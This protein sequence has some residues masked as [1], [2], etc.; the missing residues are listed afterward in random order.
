MEHIAAIFLFCLLAVMHTKFQGSHFIV[1]NFIFA[2]FI[3]HLIFNQMQSRN[4]VV[5]P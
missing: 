1:S 2:S 3:I 4:S 5:L